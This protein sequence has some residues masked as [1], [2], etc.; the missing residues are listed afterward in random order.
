MM[1]KA[2]KLNLKHK[3]NYFFTKLIQILHLQLK[4]YQ[5]AMKYI[6]E[7]NIYKKCKYKN[8]RFSEEFMR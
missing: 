1:K 6:F 3:N 2:P 8:T 5:R 7:T 4:K